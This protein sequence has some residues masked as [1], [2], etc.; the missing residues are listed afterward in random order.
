MEPVSGTFSLMTLSNLDR[1]TG[2]LDCMGKRDLDASGVC[3]NAT[4]K[5]GE[6]RK[7]PRARETDV[8]SRT[9]S[10][11]GRVRGKGPRGFWQREAQ[12]KRLNNDRIWL[13]EK[14][15]FGDKVDKHAGELVKGAEDED[16]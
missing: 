14:D 1:Y 7:W 10:S 12:A 15:S 11:I 6:I 8:K 4:K 3:L 16:P 5:G 2:P 13:F 9:L